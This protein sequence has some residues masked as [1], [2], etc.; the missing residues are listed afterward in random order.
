[1]LR[2]DLRTLAD[3][4]FSPLCEFSQS[5]S[6]ETDTA[7]KMYHWCRAAVLSLGLLYLRVN[8][9][10]AQSRYPDLGYRLQVF[11]FRAMGAISLASAP[12]GELVAGG[13]DAAR[14]CCPDLKGILFDIRRVD[15]RS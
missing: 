3:L 5:C 15:S 10:K 6:P 4:G 11:A 13:L 1:M 2:S 14:R 7:A 8:F 9:D 12:D